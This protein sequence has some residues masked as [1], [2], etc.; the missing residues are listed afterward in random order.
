VGA[1][2]LIVPPSETKSSSPARGKP[3]DLDRL[4]FPALSATRAE[5]LEAL[6]ETS[7]RS[8]AFSRLQVRPTLAAEV[9]RNTRIRELPTRP[10]AELYT[11][12]LH[13]GLALATLDAAARTRAERSVVITSALWG[14]LRPSDAIPAYRLYICARLVGLDRLEPTWR[15]VLPVVLA[16]AAGPDGVV[17]DLRSPSYQAAGRPLG[18]ADRTVSL[19][20]EQRTTGGRIGDVVAKRMRGEIGRYLLESGHAP[21]E[22]EDLAGILGERWPVELGPGSD[23]FGRWALTVFASD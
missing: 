8:D 7:A 21:H 20:V 16:E 6:I 18:L 19:R 2:L 1:V 5:I 9:A 11:G 12:P 4:S 10:A 3:L 22:P 15:E 13:E 23:R 17:V 14:A